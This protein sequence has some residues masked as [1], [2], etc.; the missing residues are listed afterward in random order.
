[1]KGGLN[2]VWQRCE[3]SFG[4]LWLCALIF[5]PS[6]WFVRW[7]SI[8]YIHFSGCKSQHRI[9][10]WQVH[11]RG[12]PANIL[13]PC[14]NEDSVKWSYINSLKEVMYFLLQFYFYNWL[15]FLLLCYMGHSLV[16]DIVVIQGTFL[17]HFCVCLVQCRGVKFSKLIMDID[18]LL[19]RL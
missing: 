4:S 6:T 9:S 16:V 14:E 19:N 18:L 8:S 15:T 3:L 5:M 7:N 12:Y 11:F 17:N 2:L 1:M 13:T 10:F